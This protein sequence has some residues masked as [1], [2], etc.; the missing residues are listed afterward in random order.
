M[1]LTEIPYMYLSYLLSV[2]C[3]ILEVLKTFNILNFKMARTL[4]RS[5][6]IQD[7]PGPIMLARLLSIIAL[8]DHE[9]C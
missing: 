4:Y 3:L 1:K 9:L 6:A 5:M 8:L 7:W 2:G